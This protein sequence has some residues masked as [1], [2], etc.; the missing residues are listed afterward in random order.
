K[1]GLTCG[2]CDLK[3]GYSAKVKVKADREQTFD[4]ICVTDS[5]GDKAVLPC[6]VSDIGK[7]GY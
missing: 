6:A 5:S 2:A 3:G 4:M 7:L 1:Y